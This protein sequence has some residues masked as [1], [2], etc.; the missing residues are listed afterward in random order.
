[1]EKLVKRPIGKEDIA[2]DT[3]G[4][5]AK[6]KYILADG[7]EL[8]ITRINSGDI[9]V[10]QKVRNRFNGAANVEEVFEILK[11]KQDAFSAIDVMTQ[12]KTLEILP[13]NSVADV[14]NLINSQKKN[15]GGFTLT[16]IFP[17]GV[18]QKLASS[19]IFE[20]FCNG[21]ILIMGEN[22]AD[23]SPIYDLADISALFLFKN[24]TASVEIRNIHFIHQYS[25]YAI[26]FNSSLYLKVSDCSFTGSGESTA[27]CFDGSNGKFENCTFY[28]DNDVKLIGVVNRYLPLAGGTMT[29]D[30]VTKP[31][32]KVFQL[33]NND[34]SGSSAFF[35]GNNEKVGGVLRLV[36]IDDNSNRSCTGGWRLSAADGTE[37][38][39]W[40]EGRSDGSICDSNGKNILTSGNVVPN[41]SA[42]V[43]LSNNSNFTCP[44]DGIIIACGYNSKSGGSGAFL[45]GSQI[46]SSTYSLEALIPAFF[47]FFV[48][49]NNVAKINFSGGAG[50][51]GIKFYP[52][53]G[54][55]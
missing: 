22:P 24:C 7:R 11:E 47:C 46:F 54:A 53:K 31:E 49:K 23:F 52:L 39:N 14:V 8:E 17:S 40:I 12:D 25:V 37:V 9:P 3:A 2:F 34:A 55:K 21:T 15:L 16:F 45:N 4:I 28:Q 13:E 50:D 19:I 1:M 5:S 42:G 30:I 18:S 33:Y 48:A 20:D 38:V 51:S 6:D 29:G 41:Y 32:N 10:S 44:N 36:G 26:E 43:S 27:L 35:G